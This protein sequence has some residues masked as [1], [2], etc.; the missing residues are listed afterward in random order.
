M[1]AR[2]DAIT[3]QAAQVD[4]GRVVGRALLTVLAGVCWLIGAVPGATIRGLAWCAVAVR[5]GYRD[6]R[7]LP[8]LDQ[9]P[10]A[11]QRPAPLVA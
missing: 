6:G 5:V 3:A 8:R 1:T 2:L 7:G 4:A 10:A 11:E 9:P